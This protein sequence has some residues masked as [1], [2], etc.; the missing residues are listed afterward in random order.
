M[1][2]PVISGR[3][4]RAVIVILSTS[5]FLPATRY[6]P[7]ESSLISA[8]ALDF[9]ADQLDRMKRQRLGRPRSSA[10][11]P[12]RARRPPARAARLSSFGSSSASLLLGLLAARAPLD[13]RLAHQR[14]VG[15]ALRR[16]C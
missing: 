15:F 1:R 8:P 10:R 11:L 14:H 3:S 6:E 2:K 12:R 13:Q 5:G 4:V 7:S 16:R 9:D